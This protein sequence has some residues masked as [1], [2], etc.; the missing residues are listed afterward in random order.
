MS[1]VMEL[2]IQRTSSCISAPTASQRSFAA[3]TSSSVVQAARRRITYICIARRYARVRYLHIRRIAHVRAC[4]LP[5]LD[6]P[7]A[8]C[9]GARGGA[10]RHGE[11]AEDRRDVMVDGP[12]REDELRRDLAV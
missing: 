12:L 7:E 4:A 2:R 11:L 10:A 9:G 6:E 1:A 5:I 8:R 3:A